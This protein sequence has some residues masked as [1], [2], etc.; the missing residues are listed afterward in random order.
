[1]V[2]VYLVCV[3]LLFWWLAEIVCGVTCVSVCL[4]FVRFVGLLVRGWVLVIM[5]LDCFCSIDC[6][7]VLRL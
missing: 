2:F 5:L 7:F 4:V 1:M 3:W 6:Y